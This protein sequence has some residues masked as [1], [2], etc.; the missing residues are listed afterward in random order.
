MNHRSRDRGAATVLSAVVAMGLLVVLWM[1][2]QLGA[3][4][5]GRHRAEGAADLAA[6][7]AAS[8]TSSGSEFG[9]SRARW[10]VSSM[11]ATM[12]SCRWDGADALVRVRAALPG[13][14]SE[15]GSV[16]A[17]ARAGPVA[18]A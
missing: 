9:C 5:L 6:L 1:G 3:V 10:V 7:A 15:F 4:L 18:R 16:S 13:M 8:H 11:D 14:L 17:R 12:V 2:V